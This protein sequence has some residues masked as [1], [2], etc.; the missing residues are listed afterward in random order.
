M[1]ERLIDA[2]LD[3]IGEGLRVLED[4]ARFVLNDGELS[5][6]FKIL[7]HNLQQSSHFAP[8]RL[9]VARNTVGDMARD[10][11]TPDEGQRADLPALAVANSR[12]VQQSLRVMEEF[13][14]LPPTPPPL[15]PHPP[16]QFARV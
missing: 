11:E 9:L 10:I 13:A 6:Q 8:Q 16:R 4:I 5:R 1:V 2:N 15:P 12:R 14:K 7:R 3:R